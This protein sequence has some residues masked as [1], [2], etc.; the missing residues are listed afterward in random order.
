MIRLASHCERGSS[1]TRRERLLELL[2]LLGVLDNQG[3]Q[4]ARASDLE[5]GQVGGL[6]LLDARGYN[7]QKSAPSSFHASSSH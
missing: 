2:G 1:R 7:V 4:V 3:V 6:A 5:L